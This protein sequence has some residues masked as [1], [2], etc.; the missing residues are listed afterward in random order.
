[1]KEG[2]LLWHKERKRFARVMRTDSYGGRPTVW[3]QYVD[4]DRPQDHDY[5]DSFSSCEWDLKAPFGA[6]IT[7]IHMFDGID[8]WSIEKPFETELSKTNQE[9]AE[10]RTQA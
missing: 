8:L 7:L 10:R 6:R 3:V 4:G 1:M 9:K 5:Q 2:D